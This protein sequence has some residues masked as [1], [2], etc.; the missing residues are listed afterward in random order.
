MAVTRKGISGTAIIYHAELL[1]DQTSRNHGRFQEIL[2][3]WENRQRRK[4][5]QYMYC[6][7][8][9][10]YISP[11]LPLSKHHP[12]DHR[13]YAVTRGGVGSSPRGFRSPGRDGDRNRNRGQV[14]GYLCGLVTTMTLS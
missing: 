10:L 13:S 8:H 5:I 9:V 2:F 6:T 4:H 3:H 14:L 11:P 7:V 12:A 1:D